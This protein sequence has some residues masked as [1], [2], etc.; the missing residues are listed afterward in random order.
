M[1]QCKPPE[2]CF[3]EWKAREH[4]VV[5]TRGEGLYFSIGRP[6]RLLFTGTVFSSLG[7]TNIVRIRVEADYLTP[8]SESATGLGY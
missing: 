2:T 6:D 5:I 4:D 1:I 3:W 8:E 7:G